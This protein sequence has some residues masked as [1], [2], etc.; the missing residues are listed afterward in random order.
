MLIYWFLFLIC[1]VGSL[2]EDSRAY[3]NGRQKPFFILITLLLTIVIGLRYEVGGD[4][5]SY[6]LHL[7][8]SYSF[9]FED[10]FSSGDPGYNLVNW[11]VANSINEVWVVNLF[12]SFIFSIGLVCFSRAQPRTYL[13][14]VV[15]IP[16][17]VIVVAMGYTRQSV[18]IGFAMIG[19]ASL[20][21]GKSNLKFLF[22]IALAATFHKTA[23]LLVPIAAL[24]TSKG[25]VW[26]ICW[27]GAST[28]L[29]YYLFLESSVDS[30]MYGYI[31]R[32]YNSQGAAIRVTMNALPALIFMLYRK[33]FKLLPDEQRL[34]TNIALL[35]IIFVLFLNVSP[36]TTAVD[37]M[38]LYLIP[39]QIF[40]LSRLPNAFREK[41]TGVG[42]VTFGVI[43]YSAAIQFVWLNYAAN[44]ASWLPYRFFF[45]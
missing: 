34:W 29:L 21:R 33:R 17:L 40:V 5:N 14:L 45:I 42:L 39:I 4:W 22:W 23:L 10:N 37:R 11:I 13:A 25:R 44:A 16:Y 26:T 31:E 32:Q 24:S 20:S 41:K 19:L 1:C 30:L 36:S 15:A 35:A 18:A 9:S 3:R 28:V 2:V 12:C 6:L 7:Q 38:A 43:L 27:I 8:R